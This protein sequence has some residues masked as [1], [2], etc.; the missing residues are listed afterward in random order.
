MPNT[1]AMMNMM[2]DPEWLETLKGQEE[3]IDTKKALVSVGYAVPYL[4]ETGEV[5]NVPE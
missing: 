4:L 3:Y 2:A 5:L 1:E